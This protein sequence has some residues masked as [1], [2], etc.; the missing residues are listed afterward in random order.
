V[1][2]KERVFPC[3]SKLLKQLRTAAFTPHRLIRLNGY[4]STRP[5]VLMRDEE[6]INSSAARQLSLICSPLSILAISPSTVQHIKKIQGKT[7]ATFLLRKYFLRSIILLARVLVAYVASTLFLLFLK[8]NYAMNVLY[9][10]VSL[11]VNI[12]RS[13]INV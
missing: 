4:Q 11:F 8:N 13:I 2:N 1:L 12:C 5:L 6:R 3:F 9:S 7:S 10:I